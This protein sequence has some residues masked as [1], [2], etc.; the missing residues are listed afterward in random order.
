M[1][2]AYGLDGMGV[3][4]GDAP[5]VVPGHHLAL[6]ITEK[7]KATA[8]RALSIAYE[9][10]F[11]RFYPRR[12]VSREMSHKV[13]SSRQRYG[14]GRPCN[15]WVVSIRGAESDGAGLSIAQDP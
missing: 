10:P 7:I 9:G 6:L 13:A 1:A 12:R 3:A 15:A 5:I 4:N 11:V 14:A 8:H 2:A